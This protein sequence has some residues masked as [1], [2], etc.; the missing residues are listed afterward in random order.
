MTPKIRQEMLADADR[1]D[2]EASR[3]KYLASVLRK[4]AANGKGDVPPEPAPVPAPKP[5]KFDPLNAKLP[6]ESGPFS[7]AWMDWCEHRRQ[8]RQPLTAK[9]VELQLKT[10]AALTEREG[11]DAMRHAIESGWTGLH[12]KGDKAPAKS[13]AQRDSDRLMDQMQESVGRAG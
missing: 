11:I 1:L 2:I 9:S 4:W 8:K 13:F 12:A 3:L 6:Y 5:P 7:A 10:L